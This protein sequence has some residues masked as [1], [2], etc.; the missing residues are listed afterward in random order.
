[1]S[2]FRETTPEEK[3]EIKRVMDDLYRQNYRE[4]P[5]V[6]VLAAETSVT[7]G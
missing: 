5:R 2:D 1:M 4:A 3:R 6:I 7:T